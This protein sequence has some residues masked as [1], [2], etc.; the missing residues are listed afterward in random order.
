VT[1][2][3]FAGLFVFCHAHSRLT[4]LTRFS[5]VCAL[6]KRADKVVHSQAVKGQRDFAASNP[7]FLGGADAPNLHFMAGSIEADASAPH[8]FQNASPSERY[9]I[10]IDASPDC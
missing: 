1:S 3:A 6:W 5:P 4:A 9:E 8:P 2:P 10:A 7:L